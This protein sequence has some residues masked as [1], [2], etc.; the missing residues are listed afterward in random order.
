MYVT[1]FGFVE[2]LSEAASWVLLRMGGQLQDEL[3]DQGLVGHLIHQSFF[4]QDRKQNRIEDLKEI[5]LKMDC[6]ACRTQTK[7]CCV[8]KINLVGWIRREK[9]S[10]L[11]RTPSRCSF[12]HHKIKKLAVSSQMSWGMSARNRWLSSHLRS[13]PVKEHAVLSTSQ[14]AC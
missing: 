2:E 13:I 11:E 4:L 5:S 10:S 14:S 1:Y 3:H 6:R 7:G 12:M 8:W 9:S